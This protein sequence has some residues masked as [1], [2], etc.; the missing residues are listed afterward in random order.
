MGRSVPG[1]VAAAS[2]PGPLGGV[3]GEDTDAALS[4]GPPDPSLRRWLCVHTP[5][6]GEVVFP[7]QNQAEQRNG[8]V[9][10]IHSHWWI[11]SSKS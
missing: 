4:V 2:D 3:R 9:S 6:L 10:A 7:G 5:V 8:R 11:V 1:G